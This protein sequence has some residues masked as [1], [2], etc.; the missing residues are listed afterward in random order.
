[1]SIR[2]GLIVVIRCFALL[3]VFY[4][5]LSAIMLWGASPATTLLQSI[6][7][8]SLL[9][10]PMLLAFWFAGP[11]IDLMTP[12]PHE[13]RPD[14]S[15]TADRLQAIAFSAVGAYILYLAIH[16]TIGFI[17]LAQRL[18]ALDYHGVDLMRPAIGATVSWIAGLF[19]FV[20]APGLRHMLATLRERQFR[21]GGEM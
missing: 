21:A 5:L 18:T 17:V 7:A 6:A 11:L 8:V 14:A 10:V 2:S 20:G 9:F 19:L 13:T 3:F 12:A 16:E 15:L 4:T 1:M